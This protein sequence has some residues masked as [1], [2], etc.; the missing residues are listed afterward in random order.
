MGEKDMN[1]KRGSNGSGWSR[2][3]GWE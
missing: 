3:R 1:I 2:G